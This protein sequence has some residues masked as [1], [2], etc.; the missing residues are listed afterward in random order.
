MSAESIRVDSA[1]APGGVIPRRR[2]VP[3]RGAPTAESPA[4]AVGWGDACPADAPAPHPPAP[5]PPALRPP[6]PSPAAPSPAA[7]R[8]QRPG[9]HS[10]ERA[11][12]WASERAVGVDYRQRSHPTRPGA[13]PARLRAARHQLVSR[14]PGRRPGSSARHRGAGTGI[15]HRHLRRGGGGQ[16]RRR[17][18]A[19]PAPAHELRAGDRR[20]PRGAVGPTRCRHRPRGR[21]QD[22][23]RPRALRAS[24]PALGGPVRRCV[25]RSDATAAPNRAQAAP[26]HAVS[27]LRRASTAAA[28]A[29]QRRAAARPGSPRRRAPHRSARA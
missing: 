24:L 16:A 6:A 3:S 12:R 26:R 2:D 18:G 27:P 19:L 5:S 14:P 13:A 21:W 9:Q 22:I 11:G 1:A 7:G 28:G 25:H 4:P 15:G 17:T 20:R 10:P 8:L 29:P 23:G